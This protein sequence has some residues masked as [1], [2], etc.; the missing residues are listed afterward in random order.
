MGVRRLRSAGCAVC[1][2]VTQEMRLV[3]VRAF[4]IR[5]AIAP[6]L[7]W[8]CGIAANVLRNAGGGRKVSQRSRAMKRPRTTTPNGFGRG[9]PP[10]A[11]RVAEHYEAVLRAKYLDLSSVEQIAAEWDQSAKA[12]ESLL[13]RARTAFRVAYEQRE[14]IESAIKKVES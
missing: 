11:R 6:F 4:A 13:T 1:G 9:D 5:S 2:D 7:A 8:L 14:G 3:A 12:I 10:G